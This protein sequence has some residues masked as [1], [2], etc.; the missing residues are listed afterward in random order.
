MRRLLASA[1]ALVLTSCSGSTASSPDSPSPTATAS[2]N[3]SEPSS[4]PAPSPSPSPLYQG[5]AC[6][7]PVMLWTFPNREAQGG[8]ID[9]SSGTFAPDPASVM[10]FDSATGFY[11]TPDQPYLYGNWGNP[12]LAS[13]TYD[14]SQHRWL[15][16]P[17]QF[18]SPDGSTY[19][20]DSGPVSPGGG[21]HLVDVATGTDRVVPGTSRIPNANYF[22]VGFLRDGVYLT[23]SNA[24]GGGGGLWRLDPTTSAITQ[25]S[26]D[27]PGA[28]VFVGETP[29]QSPPTPEYP[30]AWWTHLS[31][32]FS[33]SN[34][35][36]VYFQYL[37]GVAGQHGEDWFQR[38]GFLMKL[39]GVDTT[40]HAIVLAQS[41]SQVE[42][43]LLA[44][45]NSATQLYSVANNGSTDLQF[46]TAVADR[47]GWWIGSPTGVFLATGGAFTLVSATPAVVVGTCS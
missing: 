26:T 3:A 32:T 19:A 2:T 10:V 14:L 28:G 13:S 11:R 17:P 24:G 41:A 42:V 40:G 30:D 22:V 8:F 5:P 35:P 39:I 4:A 23:Q 1:G 16:V 6:Q 12:V 20:Y 9:A 15:P 25:V 18:V 27:A 21:V 45:P 37:S 46:K 33:A 31:A 29:L 34:D 43:W 38:P 7:L 44:T 36:Y 47:G